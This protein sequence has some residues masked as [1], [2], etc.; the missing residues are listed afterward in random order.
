[1]SLQDAIVEFRSQFRG[2]VIE[3]QDPAYDT[4]RKV[5]NGM[6]DRKP[7]LIAKVT[8]VADVITAVRAARTMGLMVSICGGRH[9]AGGLGV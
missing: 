3:P 7:R 2:V 8:D 9:N 4:E 1:M 6:I 5:Y